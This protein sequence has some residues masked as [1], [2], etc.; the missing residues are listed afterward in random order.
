MDHEE[1]IQS[2]ILEIKDI[3]ED[4]NINKKVVIEDFIYI[5]ETWGD[6]RSRMK[7]KGE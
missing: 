7:D 4:N 6:Y 3:C 1:K 5:L 2:L